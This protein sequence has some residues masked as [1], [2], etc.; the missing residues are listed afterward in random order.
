[1]QEGVKTGGGGGGRAG[2]GPSSAQGRGSGET[3]G[4]REGRGRKAGD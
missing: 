4:A 3:V 2:L 1:M